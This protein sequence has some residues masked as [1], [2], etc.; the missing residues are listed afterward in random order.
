VR[1]LLLAAP[2]AIAAAV[3]LTA[4]STG[5]AAAPAQEQVEGAELYAAQCASCHG[6]DGKGVEDKGPALTNEGA[7][8]ADFVLRTGRMP[9]AHPHMEAQRG[10]TRF[11]EDEIRAL[12]EHVAAFGEGPAIPEVD[13]TGGDLA[14]GARLYQLNCAACHVAS[15]AGAAI[16]GGR[17]A[18]D[19]MESTPTEIGEAIRIGPGAMP[20]FGSFSDQDI[21]DVA[22]YI[23]D[24]QRRQTTAPDDF[25]GVGPVAEGLA[26]WLLALLP[27]IAL[28]R[29]IGTPHEGRDAPVEPSEPTR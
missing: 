14:R 21:N 11:T 26:A 5:G 17:K 10:P 24:L 1:A 2:A 4:L 13:I 19:L 16:G 6:V 18:P 3:G 22:A 9:M 23:D 25:G 29:W 7:A 28:T 27:L 12:V 15:G 8:A 20:V